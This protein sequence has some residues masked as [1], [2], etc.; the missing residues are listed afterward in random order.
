MAY[1]NIREEELKN[2][3]AAD[4]FAD[5]DTTQIIGNIDFCV[6]LPCHEPEFFETEYL[7][8]AEAKAGTRHDIY[9]S[10]V[11]LI[12]TI[13]RAR[14]FDRHLPPRFLGAFDAEKIAFLPYE[15]IIDVFYVNDFN[16]NVTPSDHDSRE[17]RQLY[18]CVSQSLQAD[19]TTYRFDR[20][21]HELRQF[22]RQN[23]V[24]KTGTVSKVRI[25]KNNFIHIYQKWHAEV[26]PHIN[27]NWE[28]AK[29]ENLID[30]DF[31]LADLLSKDN[32]SL[33]DKLFVLLRSDHYIYNI[34]KRNI[35]SMRFDRVDFDD[36]QRAHTAFWNRYERPPRREYW[37]YIVER[38][39]LLVPQDIRERR[40][41][42]FT[43]Q[44][45]VELS[46]QY[47]ADELGDSWQDEYTVWDC[48][49]GT[50]NLL[51]GL[52]NKYNVWAST[53]DEQD[54]RAMRDRIAAGSLNLLD[55]HVF[56]FDFLN[57]DFAKLPEDLR[58]IITDPERRRKLVVYINPPYA[59][60]GNRRV[61]AAGGGEQKTNVAVKHATYQRFLPEIGIAGRELFAQ[62]L[63]RIYHEIPSSVLAEFSKLKI[64]QA[65]NFRDFRCAFRAKL[66]RNFIV[67]ANTF[68]NVKGKFPI[69]FFIWDLSQ[70]EIFTHTLSDVFDSEG[71]LIGR[72]SF[73]ACDDEPLINDW[74]IKTRNRPKEM[75]IGYMSCRSHDFSNVAY[76][77]IMN[78]KCQMKS[79]R[80]SWVTDKNLK[81]A[82]IYIG[83][84]HCIP[85]TWLNDRDQFLAPNDGWIGDETFITDC[86][87][88]TLF[89]NHIQSQY[90]TNHWIPFTEAEVDAKEKFQSHFMSDYIRHRR[91]RPEPENDLFS[92]H[93][94]ISAEKQA[95]D[96]A[97]PYA[98]FSPAARAVFDAGRALWR[99]YHAQPDAM[100]DAALYDIR[101]HFQGRNDK[102]KM[103]PDSADAEYNRLIADLREALR[104]LA[105]QIEPKVY[106]YGFLK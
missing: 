5:Y 63:I 28:D 13:G 73:Y 25:S 87:A 43:P 72:K 91:W 102:G 93:A 51:N 68:D 7:L 56:Q 76:N 62:F 101:L 65:P 14:T 8:W 1:D 79:P 97:D 47:L 48:A 75:R 10:F 80:G 64:L 31:Y 106:K 58:K 85:A 89:T 54:V 50:G 11:Q 26:A 104:R 74:L 32:T 82:A 40:G 55:K 99:Y 39:D 16:W 88:Y 84:C 52:T 35:G 15:R 66:G 67:P 60:A 46:Q 49:A 37:D 21:A 36:K 33:R 45:W 4:W 6:A 61:I 18:D 95:H 71:K 38:R 77:F 103:N 27:I 34:Q 9:A 2:K 92:Q 90:G 17:F 83:V 96:D 41:S 94:S 12:L 23:F 105:R 20:D 70:P 69:G 3:V 57:D 81:E 44:R 78:D 98:P 86:L 59:E 53:L 100:P 19:A 30:A 29:R 22:I 24:V 42:Y